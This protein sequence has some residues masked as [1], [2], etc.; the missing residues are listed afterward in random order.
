MKRYLV[1]SALPYANG[2]LHIGHIAGSNLP[3]DIFVKFLKLKGEDVIYICGTDEHGAPI[4][5]AAEQQNTTPVEIVKRYHDS[6]VRDFEGLGFEF[7]NFSGTARP[8]HHKLAQEFFT[9]LLKKGF[10]NTDTTNQW[11]DEKADRFLADRYVE[12]IC[13]YCGEDGARGDQCDACGK[14]IDAVNLIDPKS[15]ITGNTPILRETKHWYLDLLRFENDLWVWLESKTYWKENVRNFILSWLDDGLIQ[16]SITRDLKWGVPVPLPNAEGK[17]L[18]VWFEAPIG[19]I[20]STIEWSEQ[21]GKPDKWKEY[22][23]NPDTRMIHFLGKDNIPFHTIIWPAVLMQQDK[24]YVLPYDV[25]ANE[26]LNLEGQKISTSRNWAVWVEDFLK[27]F[28]GELLRYTLAA[29]APET[30]DSDFSWKDFQ[31]RVNKDLADVLGNLANRILRFSEKHFNSKLS[32]PRTYTEST[33]Q[34]LEFIGAQGEKIELCYSTYK[35]R[36]AVNLIIDMAREG[37]RFFDEAEPW[38]RIKTD[39]AAAEESLWVC[40]R[41]LQAVSV[42]LYPVMPKHMT[43][44]RKMV[45]LG[46]ERPVWDDFRKD[47]PEYVISDVKVLFL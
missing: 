46:D 9:N 25:P 24:P 20:S 13:P 16:R 10:I 43:T 28:D 18:Y 41:V 23:L 19:Y 33:R 7:E 39:R 11:Y 37:N 40:A 47:T 12:G 4:T 32:T 44:L 6:M 14:L 34:L 27:Y 36:K 22:W 17:V 21:I 29:N 5:I 2:K 15:K 26:Y 45:G 31:N 3:A 1:T 30:K 38:K 8:V 35:V 42:F